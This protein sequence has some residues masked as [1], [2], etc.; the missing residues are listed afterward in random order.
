M[1]NSSNYNNNNNNETKYTAV[2]IVLSVSY[3]I[4]FFKSL[5]SGRRLQ[6]TLSSPHDIANAN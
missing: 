1:N 2:L 6:T 3:V 5:S 4:S